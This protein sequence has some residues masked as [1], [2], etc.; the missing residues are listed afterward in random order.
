MDSWKALLRGDPTAW[1]LEKENPSVRYFT[2]KD[3]L[4]KPEEDAEVQSARQ[5][6]MKTGAVPDL[7]T[8]QREAEYRQTFKS[9]Y[10]SKYEGLVWSLIILAELGASADEQVKEECE[11]ILDNSQEREDGGFAMHE[12]AKTGGGRKTEVIPC[13]TGNMVWSL[14]KL[15]YPDDP[16]LQRGIDWM[17]RF[18]RFNDGVEEEA[19]VEPYNR[20]EMCWGRHTCHMGVVKALKALAVVPE[21]RRTSEISSTI[22]K[23]VEFLLKHRVYKRSHD[24]DKISKP[25]WL[26][27]G[28]P[29]M[30]QT[31]VLE[32]LDILTALGIHD[33]RMEEAVSAVRARQDAEGRWKMENTYDLL[34]PVEAKGAVSKWITL[35]AMRVLKRWQST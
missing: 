34:V 35:R 11:Y 4:D 12:A 28:F 9:F 2:L 25:G 31:D 7:L 15:G 3:I 10:T 13:L 30:Y 29:L 26:K 14:I 21:A 24:P 16:R 18:M 8:K 33:G 19:Q 5:E 20:Y 1:L 23:S 22:H 6:I 17:T 32:I 27:F